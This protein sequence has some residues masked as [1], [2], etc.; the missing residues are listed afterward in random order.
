V[1]SVSRRPLLASHCFTA[2]YAQLAA[3]GLDIVAA[4][5]ANVNLKTLLQQDLPEAINIGFSRPLKR[6]A[7]MG[8]E[9]NH[10]D[11]TTDAAQEP[12]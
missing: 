5:A 6:T 2:H 3:G 10:V 7:R 12:A 8:I 9:W 1:R 11:L 4:R